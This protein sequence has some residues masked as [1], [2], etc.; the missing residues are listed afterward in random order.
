MKKVFFCLLAINILFAVV[1]G[2]RS[3]QQETVSVGVNPE[4]IVLLSD[5]IAC[6]IWGDF[7]E[8]EVKQVENALSQVEL[9]RSYKKVP[10]KTIV[11]YWV[12]TNPFED[13][14][15]VEREINKLRNMGII[16]Y[17]VQ[18]EGKWLNAI[19]FGEF[20]NASTADKLLDTLNEKIDINAMILEYKIR[21]EKF[22][23][24]EVDQQKLAELNA[25]AEQ[26]PSSNLEQSTCE[27]L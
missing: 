2:F 24:F 13:R 26:F 23:I 6:A 20:R 8:R 17:R 12:H 19:S 22:L 9:P 1:S 3:E 21:H 4:K 27:R 16:S 11:R 10:A 25:L 5:S 18:E 14:Q 15:T 7:T